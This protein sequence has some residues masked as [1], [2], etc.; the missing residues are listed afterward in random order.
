VLHDRPA[1]PNRLYVRRIASLF[2]EALQCGGSGD[3]FDRLVEKDSFSFRQWESIPE[4]E[5]KKIFLAVLNA[6][7]GRTVNL[8]FSRKEE[9]CEF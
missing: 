8:V 3:G 2:A 6:P 1:I 4:A 9:Q 7:P 5:K